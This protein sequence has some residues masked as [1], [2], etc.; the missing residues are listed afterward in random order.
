MADYVVDGKIWFDP[1][2]AEKLPV[3]PFL[4]SNRCS[5][6]PEDG[7]ADMRPEI[8]GKCPGDK[9]C[10]QEQMQVPTTSRA[11][12]LRMNV[13]AFTRRRPDMGDQET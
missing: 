1:Q 9:P 5:I 12:G 6:Y 3:C 4:E 7:E 11:G 10:L 8:C 2:T 13:A